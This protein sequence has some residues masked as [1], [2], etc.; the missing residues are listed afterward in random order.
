MTLLNDDDMTRY[1]RLHEQHYAI[2]RLVSAFLNSRVSRRTQDKLSQQTFKIAEALEELFTWIA[3]ALEKEKS[4]DERLR[5]VGLTIDP[6]TAETRWVH[7]RI[8]GSIMRADY[9][10]SP[11]GEWVRFDDLPEATREAL[12]TRN[13]YA[14]RN[15]HDGEDDDEPFFAHI[16]E[17]NPS[18]S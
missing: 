6:A 15:E 3:T 9:A 5:Q 11:G 16:R 1:Y 7:V 10:R 4:E 12:T 13:E 14:E 2:D 8:Y 17:L 18:K